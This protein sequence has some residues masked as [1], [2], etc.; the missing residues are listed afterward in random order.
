MPLTYAQEYQDEILGAQVNNTV[1]NS[2][3]AEPTG[4]AEGNQ[5]E[6]TDSSSQFPVNEEDTQEPE[7]TPVEPTEQPQTNEEISP[8]SN[9]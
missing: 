1:V 2:P 8:E 5:G 9:V 6:G 7:I 3:E 4:E